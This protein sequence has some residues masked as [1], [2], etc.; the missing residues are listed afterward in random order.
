MKKESRYTHLL[1][2]LG[3]GIHKGAPRS[4]EVAIIRLPKPCTVDY[5][6]QVLPVIQ[7]MSPAMEVKIKSKQGEGHE[8]IHLSIKLGDAFARIRP[9]EC[10][11]IDPRNQTV[12]ELHPVSATQ[13][14]KIERP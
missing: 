8:L 10:L 9:G 13:L 14:F 3:E 11:V 2:K 7:A 12:V 4:Q 1:N 6:A 5:L